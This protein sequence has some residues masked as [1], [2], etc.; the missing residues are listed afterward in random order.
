[1]LIVGITLAVAAAVV[2]KKK[3]NAPFKGYRKPHMIPRS[4]QKAMRTEFNLSRRLER[5]ARKHPKVHMTGR[6]VIT[7]SDTGWN[8]HHL[9]IYYVYGGWEETA[10]RL[11]VRVNRNAPE[12]ERISLYSK[13]GSW[14][15]GKCLSLECSF[16]EVEEAIREINWWMQTRTI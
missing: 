15:D 16:Q 10:H 4:E 8:G 11:T 6:F 9:E 12:R 1:M 13:H 5:V 14:H 7:L 3:H 2:L